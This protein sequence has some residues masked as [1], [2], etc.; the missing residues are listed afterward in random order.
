MIEDSY[1]KHSVALREP[2]GVRYWLLCLC[3]VATNAA[4][5]W[6]LTNQLEVGQ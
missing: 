6:L 2:L 3:Y 4:T 1:L 5:T